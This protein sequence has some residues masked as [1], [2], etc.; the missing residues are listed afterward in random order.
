[1]N[2]AQLITAL[3]RIAPP[4]LAEAWD[5]TG[6]LAGDPGDAIAG[7]VVLTI[8]LDE[9]VL[10]EA[11]ELN[12]SAIVAYHPPIFRPIQRLTARDAR[13]WLVLRA[14]RAGIV[15]YS[16]HTA[17]DAAPDGLTDWLASAIGAGDTRA[18]TPASG[19]GSAVK[20]VTFVP[21]SH[22]EQLQ[23]ALA[24]SGAGRIGEYERCSFSTTGT[25]TFQGGPGTD[26]AAGVAGRLESVQERRLEM[27][28]PAK[29]APLAIEALRGLHPYEEP[30]I[31]VYPLEPLPARGAGAGRRVMLDQATTIAEACERVKAHLGIERLKYATPDR[32]DDRRVSV[33]GAVAGAGGSM[34]DAVDAN[35][36]DLFLTGELTHHEVIAALDRG[37]SVILAGHTNSER[38][39]LP[40]LA[41]R[42]TQLLP[43]VDARVSE[44]DRTPVRWV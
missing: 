34:I 19:P 40:T 9:A 35:G 31:D 22:L 27:I 11:I 5:N 13:Q 15:L 26:P 30:A 28:C 2:A 43:S 37:V 20:I 25:G 24:A 29:A 36:C 21:E 14:I 42:M 3:E 8:D 39:Y 4:H 17:L 7:P 10:E 1:M 32:R 6:L 41:R 12:A 33:V 38:G 16:P 23:S 18:L 44:R